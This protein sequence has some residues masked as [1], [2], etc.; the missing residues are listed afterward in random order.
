MFRGRA[1][2]AG[3]FVSTWVVRLPLDT[4]REISEASTGCHGKNWP[5]ASPLSPPS[6]P[7]LILPHR[8]LVTG[9]LRTGRIGAGDGGGRGSGV[10]DRSRRS[11]RLAATRFERCEPGLRDKSPRAGAGRR[12][13]KKK[14]AG[15]ARR[16]RTRYAARP[17]V[18][19]EAPGRSCGGRGD[20][21]SR[22]HQRTHDRPA[23]P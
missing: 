2:Y 12:P 6:T 18:S 3:Q 13:S 1:P 4:C 14:S 5:I 16:P 17:W 15:T 7:S 23:A 19:N 21:G 9:R 8:S 11:A 10:T 22:R 20:L